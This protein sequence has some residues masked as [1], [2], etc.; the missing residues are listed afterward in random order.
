MPALRKTS[1]L[2]AITWLGVNVN[3]AAALE[4]SQ[5][6]E[7]I[8]NFSGIG[9]EDHGTDTRHSCSRVVSQYPKGTLIRNTR[10]ICIVSS[11]ELADIAAEMGIDALNPAWIG[12]GMVI[13]GIPDFTHIPPSTRL[14][15]GSGATLTVDIENRP[16]HLPSP[17]I[18][19]ALPGKGRSFKAAAKGRRG[20]TAWVEREGTFRIG[21]EISV[22]IPD[23][24]AWSGNA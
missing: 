6:T 12:A 22:H 1:V 4:S 11:E 8:A 9:G 17:V 16:C 20:I 14:Q 7:L 15:G 21:D 24:R 18:D 13:K 23:Q 3:R 5:T 19:E 2:G 10:Q